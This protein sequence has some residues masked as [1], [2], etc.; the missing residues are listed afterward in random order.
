MNVFK[1]FYLRQKI[2]KDEKFLIL[3]GLK[4]EKKQRL[5]IIVGNDY[6]CTLKNKKGKIY[7]P[8]QKRGIDARKLIALVADDYPEITKRYLI[9]K[10]KLIN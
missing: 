3:E 6:V 7:L 2:K 5:E 4:K 8:P 10:K 1:R 9:N